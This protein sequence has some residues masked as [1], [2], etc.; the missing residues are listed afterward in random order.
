MKKLLPLLFIV[1]L[2]NCQQEEKINMAGA[3]SML[4]QTVN[5]GSM[6]TVIN[7]KQLK[8]FT[9]DH[10]I[11]AAMRF[12]D[13]LA[14]Y[15]IGTYDI[16]NG[17]VIEH[18]FY[19]SGNA[20]RRDTFVLK[21]DKSDKGYKQSY[22]HVSTQNRKYFQVEEYETVGKADSTPLDGAWKLTENYYIQK[23]GDTT[24]NPNITQFKVYKSGQ[25]I[26][27]ASY[28]DSANRSLTFFGYGN[29]EMDGNN[30]SKEVNTLSTYP[31]I[32]DSTF[33]IELEFMGKDMYK[34]TIVQS[35]DNRSVEVYERL[36]KD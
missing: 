20:A 6:D 18:F 25:F 29:F 13:S 11:Y 26:W 36:K 34:Q 32:I 21:I 35:N 14:S 16:E 7:R 23:T 3:Y 31:P 19:T 33:N 28:R 27:A 2:T 5:E 22:D 10:V 4:S 30:I 1:V 24:T 15:G 8:I 9:D 17:N 12:P